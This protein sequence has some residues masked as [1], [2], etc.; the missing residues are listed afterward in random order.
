MPPMP[1]AHSGG[2]M[3][4]KPPAVPDLGRFV[5]VAGLYRHAV[6]RDLAIGRPA[7]FLVV[8]YDAILDGLVPVNE[9][10]VGR[11]D[12]ANPRRGVA[13]AHFHLSGATGSVWIGDGEIDSVSPRLVE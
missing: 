7:V 5:R 1:P 11:L 10:P 13:N 2:A 8:H 4:V 6:G 3:P 9:P 12:D